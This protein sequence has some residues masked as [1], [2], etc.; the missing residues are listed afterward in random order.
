MLNL[1]FRVGCRWKNIKTI[2]QSVSC[3]HNPAKLGSTTKS[4]HW[5]RSVARIADVAR[6]A[7]V[8]VS[9]A[10]HVNGTRRAAQD[11]AQPVEVAIESFRDRCNFMARSL[12]AVSTKSIMKAIRGLRVPNDLSVVGFDDFGWT[13][14]FD[15]R[16][17]LLARPA[18]EIGRRAGF[19]L[20]ERITV[21]PSSGRTIK[22]DAALVA[23]QSCG[24]P[25]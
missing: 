16:P 9:T 15:P 23:R 25:K 13:N 1:A 14:C 11:P 22:L 4:M 19:L 6:Q 2:A 17:R 20:R 21:P 10:W 8:S 12:K 24:G 5:E 18:P 7:G 3:V